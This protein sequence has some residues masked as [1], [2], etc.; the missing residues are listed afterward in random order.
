MTAYSIQDAEGLRLIFK[1]N[2]TPFNEYGPFN[3]PH[4]Q[5]GQAIYKITGEVGLKQ[6]KDICPVLRWPEWMHG[7][8]IYEWLCVAPAERVNQKK[9]TA[10]Q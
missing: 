4:C 10:G 7:K 3:C 8:D 2:H 5:D 6:A 1:P 9:L